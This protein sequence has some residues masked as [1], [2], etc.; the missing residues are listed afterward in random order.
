[1]ETLQLL[2]GLLLKTKKPQTTPPQQCYCCKASRSQQRRSRHWKVCS[3]GTREFFCPHSGIGRDCSWSGDSPQ[4][5]WWGLGGEGGL[6]LLMVWS[7]C[8]VSCSQLSLRGPFCSCGT[9]I[10]LSLWAQLLLAWALTLDSPEFGILRGRRNYRKAVADK[11]KQE[12]QIASCNVARSHT[13][14]A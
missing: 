1:M 4:V 6:Q 2:K 11:W 5:P 10:F 12:L 7:R 3:L 9:G 13:S 14:S 8:A